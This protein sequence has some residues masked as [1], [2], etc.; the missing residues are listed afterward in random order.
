[1]I[2]GQCSEQTQSPREVVADDPAVTRTSRLDK[3]VTGTVLASGC[4]YDTTL[5][6]IPL[7]MAAS[8]GGSWGAFFPF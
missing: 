3:V 4:C 7:V 1:M 6:Y 5:V 8:P 2:Q